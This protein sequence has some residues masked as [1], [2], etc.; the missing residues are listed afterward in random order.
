VTAIAFEGAGKLSQVM[1]SWKHEGRPKAGP[2]LLRQDGVGPLR[3]GMTRAAALAT[4]WLAHRGKGCPLGGPPVPITY[5]IDVRS[6]PRR[7]RGV[8]HFVRGKLV[9]M[10]FSAGVSTAV[11]VIVGE[12]TVAEMVSRYRKA[13]FQVTRRFEPPFQATFVTVTHNGEA[14]VGGFASKNVIE[15]L[16]IPRTQGCD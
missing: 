4:E 13:G 9:H 5:T 15:L 6:A 3:L 1:I 14:V 11:G 12:S 7:I 2:A 10:A 16:S 8:V